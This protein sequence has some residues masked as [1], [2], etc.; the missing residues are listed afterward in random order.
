MPR[1][2]TK[3][4]KSPI[5][6]QGVQ[7]ACQDETLCKSK[8]ANKCRSCRET[9]TSRGLPIAGASISLRLMQRNHTAARCNVESRL[10]M[11][12]AIGSKAFKAG[13]WLHIRNI[14]VCIPAPHIHPPMV[15]LRPPDI[16]ASSL[17]LSLSLHTVCSP[18]ARPPALPSVWTTQNNGAHVAL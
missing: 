13:S 7:D 6:L 16:W 18:P 3:S 4:Q 15:R 10:S 11:R 9:M 17:S 14:S 5:R 12:R 2:H 8:S 1:R